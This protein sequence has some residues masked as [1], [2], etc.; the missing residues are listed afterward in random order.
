M[1]QKYFDG[2]LPSEFNGD[3]RYELGG[4]D[5][6][7]RCADAV[8]KWKE[9]ID[10]FELVKATNAPMDLIRDVDLFINDTA[11][12]KLAKDETK[13]GELGAILYQCLE[14]LRIA[15]LLLKPL[16]P[17]KMEE[18]HHAIGLTDESCVEMQIPDWCGLCAGAAIA[19]VALY[20]RVELSTA[21]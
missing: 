19:K 16:L 20:P 11:P 13:Q 12:F 14:T 7:T 15:T 2:E 21:T 8:K 6:P 10:K 18:F 9:A 5:W 4:V 3:N 17:E 1:I